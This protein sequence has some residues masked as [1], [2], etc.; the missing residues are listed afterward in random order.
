MML[1]D[2]CALWDATCCCR[3]FDCKPTQFSTITRHR[4]NSVDNLHI[5][6]SHVSSL[7]NAQ[8]LTQ[9]I[10][11]AA[12]GAN[13]AGQRPPRNDNSIQWKKVTS[14]EGEP[15]EVGM[16]KTGH[17]I[18]RKSEAATIVR[19]GYPIPV[20]WAVGDDTWKETTG[21]VLARGITRYRLYPNTWSVWKYRLE[22]TNVQNRLFWFWDETG[23]CYEVD[24]FGG[25]E[26]SVTFNSDGPA[27]RWVQ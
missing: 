10:Q 26:H 1:Q 3:K 18:E 4:F 17:S 6:L 9:R 22:F 19:V 12:Y 8:P 27:I 7:L 21:E 16:K 23:D 20:R 2:G 5:S 11:V 13:M 14:K 24:T 15:F 25:G